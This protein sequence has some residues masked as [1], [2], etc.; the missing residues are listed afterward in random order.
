M[1]VKVRG[2]DFEFKTVVQDL[3]AGGICSRSLR[4]IISGEELRFL[5]EF[6]LAGSDPELTPKMSSSGIVT[7]VRD[8]GAGTFQ[9]AARFTGYRFLSELLASALASTP[10]GGELAEA[11]GRAWGRY[12]V[13]RPA[14]FARVSD[15]ALIERIVRLLADHGFEPE[16]EGDVVN[17]RRCPFAELSDS[18]ANVVCRAHL[19]LLSGALQELGSTVTVAS[20]ETFP[21]PG[22]CVAHLARRNP[23]GE[24]DPVE[25]A[26]VV[27]R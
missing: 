21:E 15:D 13:E 8:L 26:R 4:K 18:Y 3:S 17:M 2:S 5:V 27:A 7:R 14:P 11:A 1:P 22:L 10:S 23:A 19:G 20:L 12:L 9:F 6:S 16:L 24:A 25:P